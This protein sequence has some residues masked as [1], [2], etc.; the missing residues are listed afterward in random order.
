MQPPD[1]LYILGIKYALVPVPDAMVEEDIFGY[2]D[3]RLSE[4]GVAPL[5]E[6]QAFTLT[7]W[8]ETLHGILTA[9]GQ[10]DLL[11]ENIVDGLAY[12]IVAV[13]R[14]NPYLRCEHL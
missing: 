13:L 2:I 11:T 12:A 6:E 8:H 10:K 14:S 9:M 5:M 7:L 3:S 4:I 1:S